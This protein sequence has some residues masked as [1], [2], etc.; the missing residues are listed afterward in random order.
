MEDISDSVFVVRKRVGV[1][2]LVRENMYFILGNKI[3]FMFFE[4][5]STSCEFIRIRDTLRVI[6]DTLRVIRDSTRNNN[7]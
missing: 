5:S 7:A 3:V 2:I 1:V 4:I 6:R